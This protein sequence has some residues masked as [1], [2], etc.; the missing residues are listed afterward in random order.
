MPNLRR[1]LLAIAAV[2]TGLAYVWIAAVRA[3]PG[4]KRRKAA[5]R[6]TRRS[7]SDG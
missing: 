7:A 5:A 3:V 6:V 2:L 4:V 1:V